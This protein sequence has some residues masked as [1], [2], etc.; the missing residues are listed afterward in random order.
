MT[1]GV[2]IA[3]MFSVAGSIIVG[4][5]LF[6]RYRSGTRFMLRKLARD[7]VESTVEKE[8]PL[9]IEKCLED[10]IGI[11]NLTTEDVA[12]FEKHYRRAISK[13]ARSHQLQNSNV[14]SLQSIESRRKSLNAAISTVEEGA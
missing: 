2:F 14:S 13:T 12:Y 4:L 5:P 1:V 9:N 7:I 11:V 3:L 10:Y 8:R 6:W